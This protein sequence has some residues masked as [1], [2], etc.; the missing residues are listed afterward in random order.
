MFHWNISVLLKARLALDW[1]TR[2]VMNKK[3]KIIFLDVVSIIPYLIEINDTHGAIRT[4]V[5]S[6][7]ST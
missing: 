6:I 5:L 2:N 1:W 7:R 3:S 4:G